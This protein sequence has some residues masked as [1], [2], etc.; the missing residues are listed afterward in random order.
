[1]IEQKS[2]I[3]LETRQTVLGFYRKRQGT[4]STVPINFDHLSLMKKIF[5]FII[6]LLLKSPNM[7]NSH[8][9]IHIQIAIHLLNIRTATEYFFFF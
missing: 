4:S 8:I 9:S 3:Y 6:I 7:V 1:M 5:F 2:D